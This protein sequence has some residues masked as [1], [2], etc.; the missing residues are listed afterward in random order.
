MAMKNDYFVITETDPSNLATKVI[1]QLN[2]GCELIGGV[3]ISYNPD[4]K[5][6]FYAQALIKR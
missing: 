6:M 5:K 1:E 4:S 3:S 2:N